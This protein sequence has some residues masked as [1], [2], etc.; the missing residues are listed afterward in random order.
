MCLRLPVRLSF[1][2]RQTDVER[3]NVFYGVSPKETDR[4]TRSF[5]DVSSRDR[6]PRTVDT[7]HTLSFLS[8]LDCE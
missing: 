1:F 2:D 3:R 4:Q 5:D 7:G 8:T 6:P